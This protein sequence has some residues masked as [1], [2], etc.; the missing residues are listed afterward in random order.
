MVV[1]TVQRLSLIFSRWSCFDLIL[2]VG[3]GTRILVV[4]V[5]A[6]MRVIVIMAKMLAA[7]EANE[8]PSWKCLLIKWSLWWLLLLVM[9]VVPKFFSLMNS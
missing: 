5:V 7:F 4:I 9:V 6:M 8:Y 1:M 2:M 3:S